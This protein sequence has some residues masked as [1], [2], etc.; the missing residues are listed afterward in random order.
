M[1]TCFIDIE[2]KITF[3]IPQSLKGKKIGL[4]ATSQYLKQLKSLKIPNSIIGGQI[5]GCNAKNAIKIKDKVDAY[6]LLTQGRFHA[7]EIA[8]QTG[9]PVYIATGDKITKKEIE[10]YEKKRKGR[11]NKFLHAKKIGILVSTKPGQKKLKLAEALKK[12][13]K[14]PCYLLIDNTFDIP[15]LENFNDIDIFINTACPRIEGKNIVQ[16][17]DLEDVI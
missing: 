8:T 14:K 13:I 3:K 7:I 11:I 15:S 17:R 16:A 5:L 1:Q 6:F 2:S 10:D 12:K 9:K 4:L